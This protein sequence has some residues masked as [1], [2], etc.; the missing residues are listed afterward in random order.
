M[1]L[2]CGCG[3]PVLCAELSQHRTDGTKLPKIQGADRNRDGVEGSS[4]VGSLGSKL[5]PWPFL[6]IFLSPHNLWVETLPLAQGSVK[7]SGPCST[8]IFLP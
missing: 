2:P 6:R 5:L 8:F 3:L 1:L 7:P 4:V